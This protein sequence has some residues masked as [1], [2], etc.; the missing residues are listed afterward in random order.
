MLSKKTHGSKQFIKSAILC[1]KT[2]GKVEYIFSINIY[3][4]LKNTKTFK[5]DQSGHVWWQGK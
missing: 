4:I 3:W 1:V 5:T 2:Y